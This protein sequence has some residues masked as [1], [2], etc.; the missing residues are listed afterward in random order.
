SP[1]GVAVAVSG[2]WPSPAPRF[3]VSLS[4]RE[5][6]SCVFDLLCRRLDCFCVAPFALSFAACL[7]P[8]W[9]SFELREACSASALPVALS[10]VRSDCAALPFCRAAALRR[11]RPPR[12]PRPPRRRRRLLL[13]PAL[14][15]FLL[16]PLAVL[17][18]LPALALADVWSVCFGVLSCSERA[19][20]CAFCC[21][22]L[23]LPE[24][25]CVA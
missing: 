22:D 7:L 15:S 14:F 5:A 25:C 2:V 13:R 24:V 19:A 9:L 12:R 23:P 8:D 17:L 4:F 10:C 1:A 16:L 11:L 3:A 20:V 21:L 6:C 18:S